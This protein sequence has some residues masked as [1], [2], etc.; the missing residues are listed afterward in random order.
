MRFA[1]IGLAVLV[2]FSTYSTAFWCP[3]GYY[4]ESLNVTT[5]SIDLEDGRP[6]LSS[7]ALSPVDDTPFVAWTKF[8]DAF[9]MKKWDPTQWRWVTVSGDPSSDYSGIGLN[10]SFETPDNTL[11]QIEQGLADWPALNFSQLSVQVDSLGFP[12]VAGVIEV[13][14]GN[15]DWITEIFYA[16]WDGSNWVS[17]NGTPLSPANW[18]MLVSYNWFYNSTKPKLVLYEPIVG[19]VIP[20]IAWIEYDLNA[21]D[22]SKTGYGWDEVPL[23]DAW[24]YF[25]EWNGV[26]AWVD[27]KGNLG[28]GEPINVSKTYR[29]FEDN[30]HSQIEFERD[31]PDLALKSDGT[32]V[33]AWI[34]DSSDNLPFWENIDR[35][36]LVREACADASGW[37]DLSG[38]PNFIG[39]TNVSKNSISGES[40]YTN[41]DAHEVRIAIDPNDI[42]HVAWG[43]AIGSIGGRP[44]QTVFYR[45]WEPSAGGG[46]GEWV[47]IRDNEGDTADLNVTGEIQYREGLAGIQLYEDGGQYYPVIAMRGCLENCGPRDVGRSNQEQETEM[48]IRKWD[49]SSLKWTDISGNEEYY[50]DS[51][52]SNSSMGGWPSGGGE[53]RLDSIGNVNIVFPWDNGTTS[54]PQPIVSDDV[55]VQFKKWQDTECLHLDT[56]VI[57][58]RHTSPPS[59]G[60]SFIPN[61]GFPH[62]IAYTATCALS[63][64]S[65]PP[66]PSLNWSTNITGGSITANGVLTVQTGIENDGIV[67]VSF[68]GRS[69]PPAYETDEIPIKVDS[70]WVRVSSAAQDPPPAVAI[71]GP[72]FGTVDIPIP[73]SGSAT[74]NNNIQEIYFQPPSG[75]AI[76]N[77]IPVGIGTPAA[78]ITADLVCYTPGKKDLWLYARDT[79][80]VYG[81]GRS[82]A[83]VSAVSIYA[84]LFE[85]QCPV[86]AP[87]EITEIRL[88]CVYQGAVCDGTPVTG[89]ITINANFVRQEGQYIFYNK[90]IISEGTHVITA[91]HAG[92]PIDASC[93]ISKVKATTA[94]VP[95]VPYWMVPIVLLAVMGLVR[96]KR[97]TKR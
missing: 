60:E 95:D 71:A 89:D 54:K 43:A 10:V 83:Q 3:V 13:G 77:S 21:I 75:C 69:E 8:P 6:M 82:A 61:D 64:G 73:I 31:Y 94:T 58:P 39:P 67:N 34:D 4:N 84:D 85:L 9:M 79:S 32:P 80:D 90:F 55:Q 5:R 74:D 57:S 33:I 7:L 72:Y 62:D 91:S 87:D 48:F 76:F 18:E 47:D 37:C 93:I 30:G 81:S 29:T 14:K 56:L 15:P 17:V 16:K 20:K 12:H 24:V 65:T 97:Q 45:R 44:P 36:L 27:V 66:C 2:L 59:N 40:F 68:F 78:T 70:S 52:V 46:L 25:K 26:D 1:L 42:V 41:Y 49:Q 51:N 23:G 50:F 88:Q 53:L 38:S 63:D 19:T 92:F 28:F 86:L 35:V 22:G 11:Y 96:V